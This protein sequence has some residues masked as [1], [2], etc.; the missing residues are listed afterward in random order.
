MA[1]GLVTSVTALYFGIATPFG[2]IAEMV[3]VVPVGIWFPFSMLRAY[4]AIRRRD[5][6]AHRRWM[7]RAV[8]APIGVTVIRVVG[9]IADLTLTPLGVPARDTFVAALWVGWALTFAVTEWW[10]RRPSDV[11]EQLSA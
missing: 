5:I 8:A 4:R 7:L 6:A 9:P 1:L 11:Q 3:V 2:G 10:V